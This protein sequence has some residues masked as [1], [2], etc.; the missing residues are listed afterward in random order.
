ML[1]KVQM[2]FT[3]KSVH[4]N[5]FYLLLAVLVCAMP[6]SKFLMSAMMIFLAANWVIE[7][8]FREKWEMAKS[9]KVLW[10]FVVLY[11][12]HAVWCLFSSNWDYALDD[13]RK[14]L[15]LLVIPLVVLTSDFL[16]RRKIALLLHFFCLTV[17]VASVVGIIR[18][19]GNPDMDYR[20]MFP[21]FSHIRFALN[22]CLAMV[23]LIH[24][25][26][27]IFRC[28]EL[29]YRWL[30]ALI[31]LLLMA[32]YCIVLMLLQSYTAFV[33]LS[34]VF[35]VLLG[36]IAVR[37]KSRPIYPIAFFAVL[38]MVVLVAW[39]CFSHYHSNYYTLS[40]LSSKPLATHTAQGNAYT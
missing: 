22:V 17:A 12:I 6:T 35:V 14:K 40:E 20:N 30:R 37:K 4:Q 1:R 28:K 33:I 10:A 9:N 2:S 38:T 15:P 18:H 8:R 29:K 31:I 36:W 39:L 7:C 16:N 3:R 23:V 19:F 32:I 11:V 24:V 27:K 34:V 5:I 26:H 13:L 21:H 25:L